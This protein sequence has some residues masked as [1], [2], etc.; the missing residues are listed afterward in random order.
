MG[1]VLYWY[2][3]YVLISILYDESIEYVIQFLI[4][5]LYVKSFLCY[6][7]WIIEESIFDIVTLWFLEA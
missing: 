5:K 6:S 3:L 4:K 7:S 2:D 1:G